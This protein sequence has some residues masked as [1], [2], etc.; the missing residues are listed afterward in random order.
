VQTKLAVVVADYHFLQTLRVQGAWLPL[1][2]QHQGHFWRL[3]YHLLW[4][5][6]CFVAALPLMAAYAFTIGKL[7]KPPLSWIL[8]LAA[9]VLP[10]VAGF[11]VIALGRR[12]NIQAADITDEGIL[13]M[14]VAQP[15]VDA[16]LAARKLS[17]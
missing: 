9:L 13:V 3:T 6:A 11:V 16:V 4:G 10:V 14:N 1:C 12:G 5:T 17:G 7:L 15:F 8:A 2:Q